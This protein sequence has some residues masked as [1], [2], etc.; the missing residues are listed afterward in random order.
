MCFAIIVDKK[1]GRKRDVEN[2]NIKRKPASRLNKR[3]Q[4]P[5]NFN[6]KV[7]RINKNLKNQ[8]IYF[9]KILKLKMMR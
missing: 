6:F 8:S 4:D 3:Q 5:N 2:Q 1:M 7:K 9:F